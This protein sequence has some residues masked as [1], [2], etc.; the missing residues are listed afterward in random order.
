[1]GDN[2]WWKTTLDFEPSDQNFFFRPNTFFETKIS[3]GPKILPTFFFYFFRPQNFSLK[4]LSKLNTFDLSL[5]NPSF[6]AKDEE[7]HLNEQKF[8]VPF[9]RTERLAKSAIPYMTK[10][11]NQDYV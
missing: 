10:L 8:Q 7:M 5:V 2:L 3:L 1:M 6:R 9:A 11:L 4:S